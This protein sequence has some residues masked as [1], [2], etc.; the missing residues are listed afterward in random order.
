MGGWGGG[1]GGGEGE[2]GRTDGRRKYKKKENF[3]KKSQFCYCSK[4]EK[5]F[6][7]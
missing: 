5:S 3:V 1:G 4:A 6:Y 2:E 7:T